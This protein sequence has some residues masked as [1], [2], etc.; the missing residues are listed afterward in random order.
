METK[1]TVKALSHIPFPTLAPTAYS[2]RWS[3][4][5]VQN[6]PQESVRE[7]Q[8]DLPSSPPSSQEGSD[9]NT[10][11]NVATDLPTAEPRTPVQL[12]SPVSNLDG[13]LEFGVH[14]MKP[15]KIS[16]QQHRLR[17]AG[18][19][20]SVVKGEAASGLLELMRGGSGGDIGVPRSGGIGMCG[21]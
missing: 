4:S 2:A 17:Q 9:H 18:L 8:V 10:Y 11:P 19:T 20:S 3:E 6:E 5:A 21:L 7:P 14:S 1:P 12:S 16:S 15:R 13:D